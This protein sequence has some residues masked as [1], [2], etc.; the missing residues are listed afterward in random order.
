MAN[1]FVNP[2]NF[3]AFPP[4]KARA[5]KDEDKHTGYISYTITTRTPLFIPNSSSETAFAE[6]DNNRDHKSYDFFSYTDL[7]PQKH[8]ENEPHEPV[9]PGSEMRGVVRNVYETLTDSCMGLLN[10]DEYPVKRSGVQFSPGLLTKKGDKY[11]IC[12]AN[13][14]AVGNSIDKEKAP[15]GF[16]NINNGDKCENGYLI[17]WGMGVNKRHYHYYILSKDGRG[18]P[19]TIDKAFSR[20]ELERKI[21]PLIQSYL[22]QPALKKEN[23]AAYKDYQ[24][25]LKDFFAGK[26]EVYFPINYSQEGNLIYLAP[27]VFSKE[28]SENSIGKLAGKFA[29]CKV[30]YC[31]ACSLFGYVA[32]DASANS[33]IRFTDLYVKEKKDAKDY[34]DR[35]K[36][37]IETLGGPKLGNVDFYLKKPAGASF[38][39]Y[40]YHVQGCQVRE[41]NGRL[42]GRKY[43]WHHSSFT[44]RNVQVS[45]LNKTIRPVKKGISFTGRLYFEAISNRQLKQLIWI[46][47]SGKDNL[48]LKLGAAKPLGYG[49]IEC[50]VDS[51]IERVIWLEGGTINYEN[52][53]VKFDDVTYE[54][55]GLSTSGQ[56]KAEFYKIAGLDTIPKDILITYPRTKRQKNETVM[57]KGYEWFGCNHNGVAKKRGT[58]KIEKALPN[59][60][61]SDITLPYYE[62]N[63]SNKSNNGSY[64]RRSNQKSQGNNR[65]K[66]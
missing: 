40:D 62:Q 56:V 57:T 47:N 19:Q 48:G 38:W 37:T 42:R 16:E 6:S 5:Y 1:G 22:D 60:L 17:K 46:L 18:N 20:D 45:K 44:Y 27:A 4:N 8:Y 11:Q 26:K 15:A 33:N 64:S 29:P 50:H 30:N 10:E 58:V 35:D 39:S 32:K 65:R 21:K 51:V 63:D 54:N 55:A 25:D 52:K 2:Y 34:Y 66:H 36:I 53:L 3:I 49:S 43:Y 28:V 12:K 61:D 59:I 24:N 41:Q 31:P 14:I 23:E 13:S 7:D 9:I